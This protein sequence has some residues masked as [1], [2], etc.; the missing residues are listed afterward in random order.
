MLSDLKSPFVHLSGW[1]VIH[2]CFITHIHICGT[3]SLF[4]LPALP[5]GSRGTGWSVGEIL[6]QYLSLIVPWRSSSLGFKFS[7]TV[8]SYPHYFQTEQTNFLSA[9]SLALLHPWCERLSRKTRNLPVKVWRVFWLSCHVFSPVTSQWLLKHISGTEEAVVA[10]ALK[11]LGDCQ[12]DKAVISLLTVRGCECDQ[13]V[14]RP[15]LLLSPCCALL[16]SSK[17]GAQL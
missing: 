17:L 1:K 9:T 8:F 2:R 7:F 16:C 4:W 6:F 12:C 10:A 14:S 15:P 11:L 5:T 13:H 3:S